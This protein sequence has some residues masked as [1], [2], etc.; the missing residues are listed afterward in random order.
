MRIKISFFFIKLSKFLQELPVFFLRPSQLKKIGKKFYGN[1]SSVKMWASD[2]F[3]KLGLFP[4]EIEIADLLQEKSGNLL[5]L[6]IGGGREAIVLGKMGFN[7]T[8]VDFV[9][10]LV[11]K[12]MENG[13]KSGIEINGVVNDIEKVEFNPESFDVI[14]YSCSIYSSIPGRRSRIKSLKRSGE[15]LEKEGYIACFF[16]W[17]PDVKHGRLRWKAG[18]LISILTFGNRNVEKGDIFK[19][20]LE[21][22]H[23]FSN[24]DAIGSEFNEAGFEVIKFIFPKNSHNACALLKKKALK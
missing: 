7:I 8:G 6:G 15:M 20:N 5:L 10:K 12:A 3:I 4:G 2:D 24:I 18:K 23:A 21:F 14:W 17:N 16:Y 9:G 13:E 22:L 11:E 1:S 19:D